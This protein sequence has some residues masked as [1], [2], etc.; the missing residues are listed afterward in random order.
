MLARYIAAEPTFAERLAFDLPKL[1]T[2]AQQTNPIVFIEETAGTLEHTSGT[3]GCG[4][5]LMEELDTIV[6]ETSRQE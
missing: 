1:A 2:A 6:S 3:E 4:G 5:N